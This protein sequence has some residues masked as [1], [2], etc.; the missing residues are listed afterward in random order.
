M[1]VNINSK[2]NKQKLIIK[3]IKLQIFN[4]K[5][6]VNGIWNIENINWKNTNGRNNLQEGNKDFYIIEFSRQKSSIY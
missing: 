2:K 5:K 3:K 1:K 4:I 6:L